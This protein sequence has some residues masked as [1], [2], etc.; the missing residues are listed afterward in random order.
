MYAKESHMVYWE[1]VC[2][3]WVERRSRLIFL[4]FYLGFMDLF[5]L[6]SHLKE[7]IHIQYGRPKYYNEWEIWWCYFGQN[8][9]DEENGKNEYFKRPV[10]ILKKFNKNIALVIP[11]ST[12]IKEWN[13]WYIPISYH[14]KKYSVLISHL[15]TIDTKRLEKKIVTLSHEDFSDLQDVVR[16]SIFHKNWTP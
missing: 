5:W 4:V 16:K 10:V 8:I 3:L 13:K 14:E 7:N 15:K 1:I 11:T 2:L 12:K 6:W 9:W